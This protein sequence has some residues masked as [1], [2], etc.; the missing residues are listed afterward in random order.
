MITEKGSIKVATEH[1]AQMNKELNKPTLIFGIVTAI[2]GGLIL[3][4]STIIYVVQ[5]N[6]SLPLSWITI[7]TVLL[8]CGII[9]TVSAKNINNLNG[10]TRVEEAEFFEGYIINR[11]YENGEHLVTAKVYYNRIIKYK[12]TKNYIFL[13]NTRVTAIAVDKNKLAMQE[14]NAVRSLLGHPVSG[15]PTNTDTNPEKKQSVADVQ[16]NAERV[17]TENPVEEE[18]DDKQYN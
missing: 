14:L 6:A 7:G 10:V 2:V 4:T 18:G 16:E 8:I 3:L 1:T 11:E 13:Y 15:V 5:E 9:A 12:E 17:K